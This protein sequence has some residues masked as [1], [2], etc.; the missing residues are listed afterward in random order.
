MYETSFSRNPNRSRENCIRKSRDGE[1]WC[2]IT[3]I[4]NKAHLKYAENPSKAQRYFLFVM[5]KIVCV[6]KRSG[7]EDVVMHYTCK[8]KNV[9]HK[10]A[11]NLKKVVTSLSPNLKADDFQMEFGL[12]I[13]LAHSICLLGKKYDVSVNT[14]AL[15]NRLVY[16]SH[17]QRLRPNECKLLCKDL[18]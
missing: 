4:L 7:C 8:M 5:S 10:R 17:V 18:M 9:F 14:K 3:R 2:D 15:R 12:H 6:S 13:Q 11:P 1:P 16:F